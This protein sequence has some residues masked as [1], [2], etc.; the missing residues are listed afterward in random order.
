MIRRPPRST[1]FPYTTL[2]R[3]ALR[4]GDH[5]GVLRHASLAGLEAARS[6]AHTQ[7]AAFI[8]LALEHA[9]STTAI[10]RAELL[11]LLAGE[12]YLTDRLEDAIAACERAMALRREIG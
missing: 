3:S 9:A 12:L 6:S 10:Q 4:A 1:L 5:A 7:A 2:F 8:G 11:E